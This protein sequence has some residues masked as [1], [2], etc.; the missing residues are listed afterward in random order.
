MTPAQASA[1]FAVLL[2]AYNRD[3]PAPD[4][5]GPIYERMLLDLPYDLTEQ[6]VI[7]H[8]AN[9]QWMPRIAEIRRDVIALKHDIPTFSDAWAQVN[10]R[11][12]LFWDATAGAQ[13]AE[14]LE[15]QPL[16]KLALDECGGIDAYRSA[17][18]ASQWAKRF[19]EVFESHR[20]REI[21]R[22]GDISLTET[23]AKL[24][25]ATSARRLKGNES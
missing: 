18:D 6:V 23:R 4:K 25:S 14:K 21:A 5:T 22:L 7:T 13:R 19:R 15:L 12:R 8:V 9:S 2:G 16:V 20:D 17:R 10:A 11:Q 3:I 1:I 24:K